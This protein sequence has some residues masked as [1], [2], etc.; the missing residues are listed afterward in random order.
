MTSGDHLQNYAKNAYFL[1]E[2]KMNQSQLLNEQQLDVLNDLFFTDL[3]M[4]E[5]LEKHKVERLAY[6]QWFMEEPFVLEFRR[7]LELKRLESKLIL[8]RYSSGIAKRM[9][10]L[11]MSED[12][13]VARQACSDVINHPDF[14]NPIAD[15]GPDKEEEPCPLPPELA[16]KWLDDLANYKFPPAPGETSNEPEEDDSLLR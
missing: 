13:Q 5:I 3:D 2:N 9:I 7:L 11:A 10:G 8:A 4:G 12:E 16:S 1:K 6:C 15:A 14:K